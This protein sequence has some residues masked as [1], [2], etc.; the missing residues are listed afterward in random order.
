[1][2]GSVLGVVAAN[3]SCCMAVWIADNL[4]DLAWLK[5]NSLGDL[6][7]NKTRVLSSF[8]SMAAPVHAHTYGP[9]EEC[10]LTLRHTCVNRR[11]HYI[12]LLTADKMLGLQQK[13]QLQTEQWL[14]DNASDS[15]TCDNNTS[16]TFWVVQK[17]C[18]IYDRAT[19]RKPSVI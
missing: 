16:H 12:Q 3:P 4:P 11:E 5:R 6:A 9:K 18:M 15:M 7:S 1:M 19:T 14:G 2:L 13:Q 10:N 8:A 17:V